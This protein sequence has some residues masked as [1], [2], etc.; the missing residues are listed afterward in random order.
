MAIVIIIITAGLIT[1]MLMKITDRKSLNL[2]VIFVVGTVIAAI[3]V[4]LVNEV[5]RWRGFSRT[6]K[7]SQAYSLISRSVLGFFDAKMIL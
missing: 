7:K 1:G 2:N 3:V 6:L 5:L 4:Y